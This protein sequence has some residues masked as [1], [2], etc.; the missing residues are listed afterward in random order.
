MYREQEIA[1][2][3][4]AEHH[5]SH[6]ADDEQRTRCRRERADGFRLTAVDN[7]RRIHVAEKS[8]SDGISAYR[9]HKEHVSAHG[10]AVVEFRDRLFE[11]VA[12]YL[13]C[14]HRSEYPREEKEGEKRGSNARRKQY[15]TVVYA[16]NVTRRVDNE[17]YHEKSD[18]YRDC[19]GESSF[20]SVESFCQIHTR[21]DM[22]AHAQKERRVAA[23]C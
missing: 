17:T 19:D 22:S 13:R 9:A 8:A 18:G 1:E 10:R 21:I 3:R 23:A 14:A 11:R 12:E 5:S 20:A 15:D 7:A 16:R 6:R 4:A 2:R